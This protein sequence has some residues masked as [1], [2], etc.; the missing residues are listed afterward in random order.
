MRTQHLLR[1]ALALSLLGIQPVWAE[2]PATRAVVVEG[3]AELAGNAGRAREEALAQAARQAVEQ[4]LGVYVVSE[5][6]VEQAVVIR[7]SIL[8]QASGYV[9]GYKVLSE[10]SSGG[11]YRIKIEATVGVEP[12]VEQLGKMGLLRDWTVAVI[13]AS[14]G[15]EQASTEAARTQLNAEILALGFK[16]ADE[17]T[18][19]QLNAPGLMDKIMAGNYMAALPVLRDQGVDVLITGKTYTKPS[20]MGAMETY[21]GIK[22]IFTE[23]RMDARVVRVDTGE[24]L[25]ARSFNGV[26]GGSTQ[27]IAESKAI[28]KAAQTAGG[29]F[30]KQI[31]KLPAATSQKVQLVVTG[32]VFNREKAFR[33]ALTKIHGIKKVNRTVYRNNQA[34]YEID[35]QGKADTLAELL[36]EAKGLKTFALNI[37]SVSAGK[38]E[39]KAK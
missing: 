15:G 35:Y 26:A 16:V 28:E 27:A 38:I 24:I 21:G 30:A 9:S 12:L 13:L 31:A 4:A 8:T 37:Q 22:T 11:I 3:M 14:P 34:Q 33:E 32:L 23:G 20:E 29:Y 2:A 6:L 17:N 10:S 19:V 1:L 7:D 25:A 36:S 39:A 5:T 18:L